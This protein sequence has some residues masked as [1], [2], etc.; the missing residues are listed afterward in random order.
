MSRALLR[1]GLAA[2]I[3]VYVA[4]VP[5]AGASGGGELSDLTPSPTPGAGATPSAAAD[6][7]TTPPA[8]AVVINAGSRWTNSAIVSVAVPAADN[9]SGLTLVRLSS[10]P[11][12][13]DGL[14]SYGYTAAYS[15]PKNWSLANTLYGGSR[16]NGTR[17][18]YAQWR[19]RAGNWSAVQADA[20]VLDTVPPAVR[21]P[22]QAFLA[23]SRLG[24][25]TIPVRVAWSGGDTTSG[26]WRYQLVQRVDGG[27]GV[28]VPLPATTTSAIIRDLQPGHS[29]QYAAR[30]IDRAGNVSPWAWA[31]GFRLNAYQERNPAVAYQG[32]WSRQHDASA[33]GW[34]VESARAGGASTRIS[35][36]ARDVAW[37]APRSPSRGQARV[38]LDGRLAATVSLYAS[39]GQPRRILFARSWPALSNHTLEIRAV[40]T[41]GHPRIDVDA[42]FLTGT[43]RLPTVRTGCQPAASSARYSGPR[44]RREIAL[45]F[46]DGP[47]PYT[48][49]VLDIL[50][51]YGA[52][53]TFYL[54]GSQVSGRAS[55]VRRMLREGHY[56][57]NHS[58]RHEL[59]PGFSSIA[60]TS[61]AIRAASGFTP[62]TFRPP[63]GVFDA[64]VV[65]NARA[66]GMSTIVWDVDTRDWT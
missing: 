11:Q 48:S 57:G 4:E 23:S 16:A 32:M 10:R 18:I 9:G 37:V 24:S 30:A 66:L 34:Y 2:A 40:G 53:A 65:S 49:T 41:A 42:F 63:Y 3:A 58:R 21:A 45:T 64:R 17:A 25:R 5:L 15:S 22:A 47:S 27:A 28:V 1:L 13:S 43:A 20:I 50:R 44:T 29:Y 51:R 35:F 62:C 26:I 59:K 55:L 52:R 61:A 54:V 19:D 6:A 38:Y 39:Y 31:P 33:Y 14:L 7:D 8:G 12:T 60:Y 46:D 56:P 36:T